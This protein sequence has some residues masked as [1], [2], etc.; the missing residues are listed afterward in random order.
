MSPALVD[1]IHSLRMDAGVPDAWR[2]SLLAGVETARRRR[3]LRRRVIALTGLAAAAVACFTVFKSSGR[4]L[5]IG[6]NE[7]V[8]SVHFEVRAPSAHRVSL[9]GDFNAWNASALPMRRSTNGAAWGIDV[10]LPAGRHAFAYAVDRRL[11]I[12]STAALAVDDNFGVPSSVVVV[13]YR[14]ANICQARASCRVCWHLRQSHAGRR[15]VTDD[16]AVAASGT[17]AVDR[18]ADS[19]PRSAFHQSVV[20]EAAEGLEAGRR[21][22][23]HRCREPPDARELGMRAALGSTRPTRSSSPQRA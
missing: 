20:C 5:W 14:E 12:D 4:V 7:G 9:V 2:Q 3:R 8:Q 18:L 21:R 23:N 22:S 1:A 10:H 19:V 6:G 16:V 17:R 11:M 15:I 13:A